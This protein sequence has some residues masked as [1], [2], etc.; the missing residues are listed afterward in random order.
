M[1]TQAD[2]TDFST[3]GYGRHIDFKSIAWHSPQCNRL[4]MKI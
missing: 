2:G 4:E 3:S 1:G